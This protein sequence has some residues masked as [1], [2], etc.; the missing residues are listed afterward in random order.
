MILLF[1]SHNHMI[2]LFVFTWSLVCELN[3]LYEQA[4]QDY[5]GSFKGFLR[6]MLY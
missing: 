3:E 2:Y 6:T 4:C 1:D 5:L